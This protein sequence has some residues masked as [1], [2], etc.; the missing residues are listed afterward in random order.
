MDSVGEGEGGM[1]WE[2]GIDWLLITVLGNLV[3]MYDKHRT[4]NSQSLHKGPKTSLTS[5]REIRMSSS[6]S[7][8][9]AGNQT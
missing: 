2:S 7:A 8:E 3:K 6:Y 4:L 9:I 5:L 1:I